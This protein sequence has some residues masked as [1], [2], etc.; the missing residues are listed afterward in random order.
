MTAQTFSFI[1]PPSSVMVIAPCKKETR[2]NSRL[3]RDRR[4]PKR[5]TS[6]RPVAESVST[7]L[8]GRRAHLPAFFLW[9]MPEQA[10]RQ[11]NSP[12]GPGGPNKKRCAGFPSRGLG[13]F[14]AFINLLL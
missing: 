5:P 12:P 4:V 11:R 10:R 1:T 2:S 14:L 8:A 9:G 3:F 6:Q 13:A 7:H